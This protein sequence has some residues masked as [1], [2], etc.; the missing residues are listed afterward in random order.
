VSCTD[1]NHR[2]HCALAL[3]QPC[4]A[5]SRLFWLPPTFPCCLRTR[6]LQQYRLP[7]SIRDSGTLGTFKTALK[8]HL[9]TPPTRHATDSHPSAPAIHSC[10]TYGANQRHICDWLIDWLID[11][12]TDWL[13]DWL[14][15]WKVKG[16][17]CSKTKYR[18]ISTLGYIFSPISG[19]H[20]RT[21]MKHNKT[22]EAKYCNL[23]SA[24][25]RASRSCTRVLLYR[26]LRFT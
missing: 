13:T 1:T 19:M 23:K 11:W 25:R 22:R 10:V 18:Q 2:R 6:Y 15:G 4:T 5:L 9:F 12:L 16:Q 21:L 17:C 7:A 20:G 24:R 3:L 14:W 8:T 26:V